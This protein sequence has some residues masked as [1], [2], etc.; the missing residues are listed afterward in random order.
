MIPLKVLDCQKKLKH[1]V[2]IF[3]RSNKFDLCYYGQVNSMRLKLSVA[4][5]CASIHFWG[6]IYFAGDGHNI[7]VIH[8]RKSAATG[9]LSPPFPTQVRSTRHVLFH[10]AVWT[11]QVTTLRMSSSEL[12]IGCYFGV[13]PC[14]WLFNCSTRAHSALESSLLSHRIAL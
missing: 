12:D 8:K 5:K 2:I 11:E 3:D 14:K 10:Y 9:T 6:Y 7:Q 1:S 4:S 13:D